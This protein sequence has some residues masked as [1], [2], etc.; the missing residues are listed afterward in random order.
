MQ[1]SLTAGVVLIMFAYAIPGFLFV[2][3]K[4]IK[5]E[6]IRAFSI[7]LLYLCSP[8][9]T[10]YSFQKIQYSNQMVINML[11][12]FGISFAI[13][14]I[15]M[16]IL[17]LIF[18]KKYDDARFRLITIGAAFGNIGF[19][20]VPLL[21]ALLPSY[22]EAI[23][24]SAIFVIS[25]NLISWTLGCTI[26]TRNKNHVSLK[27]IF[28]NPTSLILL[29][30][31]PLFFTS[32]SL[33]TAIYNPISLVG[34]MS[35]PI[36]MLILG[37][38]FATVKPKELFCDWTIYLTSALKLIA[39]PFLAFLVTHFLPISYPLKATMFILCCCPTASVVL[40]FAEIYKIGQKSAANTVL[41]ST[42]FSMISIPLL[43]LVL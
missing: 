33:P 21:E 3:S 40:N 39:F 14:L 35:T 5:P 24:Y 11:I 4:M 18:R 22:P 17:Y 19:M 32:T 15:A 12:F 36:C 10:L 34:R 23:T 29:I 9:L 28:I 7:V 8:C 30:A 13:Q 41:A 2:K 16:G 27:K 1:F 38:R 25:M 37:M 43:L 26:L 42:I 6:Q 20:G 31:L